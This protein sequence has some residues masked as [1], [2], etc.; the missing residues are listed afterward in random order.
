MTTDD[1]NG[2]SSSAAWIAGFV[3]VIALV[4]GIGLIASRDNTE[5]PP[6]L[7]ALAESTTSTSPPAE[8]GPED[9]ETTSPDAEIPDAPPVETYTLHSGN[10]RDLALMADGRI[11]SASN[12]RSIQIWDADDREPPIR[13]FGHDRSV[14]AV[15]VLAD[16]RIVSGGADNTVRIWEAVAGAEPI[17][18]GGHS[19]EVSSVAALPDGRVA[20]AGQDGTIN[21]VDPDAPN[22]EPEVI[23]FST[24]IWDLEVLA[25]GRI[26]AGSGDGLVRI[27]DPLA[28]ADEPTIY[29]GHTRQVLAVAALA[30]GRVASTGNDETVHVWDPAAPEDEALVFEG[31]TDRGSELTATADGDVASV[32]FDG[33][34][35]IWDVGDPSAEPVTFEGHIDR[36][37]NPVN[38][39]SIVGLPDGRLVSGDRF[40]GI[41]I[42]TAERA[43][44]DVLR[45]EANETA[46]EAAEAAAIAAGRT[47]QTIDVWV[48]D[49]G[50]TD[51]IQRLTAE[52]FTAQTGIAVNFVELTQPE[53]R[54]RTVGTSHGEFTD[55]FTIDAF[56][57]AQFGGVNGWTQDLTPF[58]EADPDYDLDDITPAIRELNSLST[59]FRGSEPTLGFYAAP[60]LAES[61]VIMFNQ[62]IMDAAGIAVPEQPTWQEIAEIAQLVHTDDVAGICLRTMP[63]WND[64]GA[65]LT[66]VVNTFGGTWLESNED[67]TPSEPQINQPDSDFRAATEFYVD[68]HQNF[69][70]DTADA[71]FPQCLELMESGRVAMWFDSTEAARVLNTGALAG[72]LG[73][74]RAPTGPTGLPGGGLWSWGFAI[75]GGAENSEA[76]WEFIRWATSQE[77][78]ELVGE[79]DGWENAP[80]G[81]RLSTYD[82]PDY[83]DA[84][85]SYANVALEELLAA[86]PSNPGTTPRPGLPGVQFVGIPEFQDIATRCT[87]EISAAI[88]GDITVDEALDA[89]QAIFGEVSQ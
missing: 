37:I 30:D 49:N 67:G 54:E 19:F 13:L 80:G 5:E 82:N 23:S 10:I 59:S 78:I 9:P 88:T 66:T 47:V 45:R 7:E 71:T 77:F 11:V 35:K 22:A 57:A 2:R 38:L 27:I 55:V 20:T 1:S 36:E 53:I 40:G 73:V 25:D 62:E 8:D 72:N 48:V 87:Q 69:G 33:T 44:A 74:A 6:T 75:P 84:N 14:L 58:A 56:E 41:F 50:T 65:T 79:Q 51:T 43:I 46:A 16:G 29:R 52:H 89:C 31:H 70:P 32:S 81:T 26:I 85:E 42:W 83:Q 15:D 34:A 18:L 63:G 12:D 4:V 68:L 86:D 60:F 21:L 3:A 61:S 64:L 76:G 17:T 24:R 39:V 28:L